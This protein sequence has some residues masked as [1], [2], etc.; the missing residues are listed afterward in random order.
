[1]SSSSSNLVVC[2]RTIGFEIENGHARGG[3][4]GIRDGCC[5][6]LLV[7]RCTRCD[8]HFFFFCTTPEDSRSSVLSTSDDDIVVV[9]QNFATA[10]VGIGA[11]TQHVASVWPLLKISALSLVCTLMHASMHTTTQASLLMFRRKSHI[12]EPTAVL[13][14]HH[15][16]V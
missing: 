7:L 2:V 4:V 12:E 13:D 5:T 1:M 9:A 6:D 16:F 8:I 15:T 3:R 10:V 11:D 14:R